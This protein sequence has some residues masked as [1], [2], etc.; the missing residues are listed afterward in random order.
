MKNRLKVLYIGDVIGP[1]GLEILSSELPKLKEQ[2]KVDFTIVNG[3]NSANGRGITDQEAK[4]I[5][6]AGANV[7]TTGNHVWDNWKGKPLLSSD[8]NIIR[9]LNY[10]HGNVGKGF[11]FYEIEDIN[12]AVLQLQGR[13]FMQMIDCPFK[14]A[15]F[16]LKHFNGKTNIIIVDFHA[17]ATAEKLAMAWFLDGKVS[18][19]IGTH[20]HIPT[21]DAT[22][23]PEGMAYIT[24]VGMTGPY[25]SVVGLR[26]DVALKR[27]MLQ[28]P[29][30]YES[31]EN[32][33]KLCAV[34]IEIDAMT[35]Q[36]LKIEQIIT[37]KFDTEVG[38]G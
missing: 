33:N 27:F 36:A 18:A 10:P 22:I 28:T 23:M 32:D 14:A 29:H 5:Y 34:F 13:T 25:D 12:I 3:E 9:P 20:T 15:E 17:D 37:P 16:A 19:L 21:A 26:K 35:G 4:I 31:A 6:N 24:D 30:K 1:S 2:Y 38:I 7:I 11:L 8:P